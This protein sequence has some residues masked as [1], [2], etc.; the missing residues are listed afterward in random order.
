MLRIMMA[1]L[2]GLGIIVTLVTLMDR[3][4]PPP[5]QASETSEQ[6]EYWL[7]D[8]VIERFDASGEPMG[9]LQ[10]D[11]LIHFAS[12]GHSELVQVEAT[13]RIS[14]TM[15]WWMR[16]DNGHVSGDRSR[17]RLTG[18]A[19]LERRVL[20]APTA[21]LH[22]ERLIFHPEQDRVETD[23]A[24]LLRRGP[25]RTTGVGMNADLTADRMQIENEVHTVHVDR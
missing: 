11:R 10:A 18:D 23:A 6:P 9:R 5:R 22:S 15:H 21:I 20:D 24:I 4:D 1:L 12:D 2:L 14:S 17:V 7:A 16:A 13:R 3:P 19:R 8:T 25:S